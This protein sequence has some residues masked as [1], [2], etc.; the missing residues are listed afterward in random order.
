MARLFCLRRAYTHLTDAEVKA[1]AA[2]VVQRRAEPVRVKRTDVID[3]E[4]EGGAG[5]RRV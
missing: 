4:T 1:N 3:T 2:P 5:Q